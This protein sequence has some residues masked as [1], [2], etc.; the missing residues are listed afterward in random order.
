MPAIE[1]KTAHISSE[2]F[3]AAKPDYA[4]GKLEYTKQ[5]AQKAFDAAQ[6]ALGAPGD[7]QR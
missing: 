7:G 5:D 2:L 1:M 4:L 6:K 3:T